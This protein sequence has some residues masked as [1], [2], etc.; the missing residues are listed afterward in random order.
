[1][2]NNSL[3]LKYEAGGDP[4]TVS[5]GSGDLG[6][7]SYGIYQF[8]S[9]AG[10]VDDFIEWLCK[11]PEDCYANYGRVLKAAYP[12]NSPN[13]VSTWINIGT[14]DAGGFARLQN[15]YAGDKY[16]NAAYWALKNRGYDMEKHSEAMRAV[17]FSR[18]IQYGPG[19]MYELYTEAVRRLGYPNLSYVDD[20]AFD[21][22][23][24]ENIYDFLADECQNA[25]QLSS[26]SYHSPKDWAN[27]SY[28]VVKVGLLNRFRNEKQDALDLLAQEGL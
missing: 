22:A 2:L 13:F 14:V 24:I 1:M 11:Y 3:V 19:N 17:L 5:S 4:A 8:S 12:V 27:G 26:G 6:G 28:T 10:V 23:M 16:Y 7:R 25:Y 9:T 15:E 20:K 21:R 18:A